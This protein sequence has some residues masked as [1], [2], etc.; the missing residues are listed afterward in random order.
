MTRGQDTRDEGEAAA[1]ALEKLNNFIIRFLGAPDEAAAMAA[2][3]DA[4]MDV[5][6]AAMG[7]VQGVC[8]RSGNLVMTAQRGFA[9][10]VL[11]PYAALGGNHPDWLCGRA[12]AA[13][14]AVVI[15]DAAAGP[16]R[17]PHQALAVAAGFR[18]LVLTPLVAPDGERLGIVTVHF[19]DPARPSAQALRVTDLHARY[20]AEAL[21]RRRAEEALRQATRLAEEATR[22]KSEFLANMSHE[23]RTPMNGI[24]GMIQLARLKTRD[25]RVQQFLEMADTSALH[26]LELVNDVLDLSKLKTGRLRLTK[27]AFSLRE[28]VGAIL[29][30]LALAAAKK[31]LALGWA[32]AD[33][34]PD[35]VAG[36]AGRLRQVLTNLVGNAV[37]FTDHGGIDIQVAMDNAGVVPDGDGGRRFR[38][39]VRDTGIGIPT[40]KLERI[41]ESFEQ[42]HA[43][44]HPEYGGTG[45][46]LSISKRLVELMGGG[47]GVASRTGE[48]SVFTF[49][50]VLLTADAAP[51]KAGPDRSRARAGRPRRILVA[52]DNRINRL[53]IEEVLTSHGHEVGFAETGRE[54]LERL[55]TERF[56][57]VLMDIRMPDMNG[58]EATRIIRTTPPAGVDPRVPVVAL[59]AYA[60]QEEIDRYAQS[61]FTAYLTKPVEIEALE[62]VLA[63]L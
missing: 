45:L 5:H 56:D 38:F 60:Q 40:D 23:I 39:T 3:L 42:A 14:R 48:G 52:E 47:L 62:R 22:S 41:F 46:G 13:G 35:Q 11:A 36:D 32:V 21:R 57:L 20:A 44:A 15:E 2:L 61:G 34:V 18:G 25:A 12:M 58:D 54:A 30:P 31:G 17:T 19:P 37:K 55:A 4:L 16:G 49:T 1:T 7:H 27:R 63:G 28:E 50:V 33:D 29:E 51:R 8:P 10:E 59:T 6:G 26:L 9:P 53:F 24:L 43:S